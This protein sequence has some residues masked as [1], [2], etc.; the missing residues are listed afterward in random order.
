MAASASYDEC[1]NLLGQRLQR[2]AAP[3]PGPACLPSPATKGDARAIARCEAPPGESA[4]RHRE[5]AAGSSAASRMA[6]WRTVI[7]AWT[8]LLLAA[9]T[10]FWMLSRLDRAGRLPDAAVGLRIPAHLAVTMGDDVP[11]SD[12]DER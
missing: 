2:R 6:G 12:A 5:A 7:A 8:F 9:T 4:S 1:G 10:G 11:S 3:S